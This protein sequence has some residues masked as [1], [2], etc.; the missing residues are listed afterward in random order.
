M[1]Y[2][3]KVCIN[4]YLITEPVDWLVCQVSIKAYCKYTDLTVIVLLLLGHH[5]VW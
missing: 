5:Q 2:L 1:C 3:K 4:L